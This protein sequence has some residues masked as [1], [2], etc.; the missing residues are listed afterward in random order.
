MGYSSYVMGVSDMGVCRRVLGSCG[1][2]PVRPLLLGV[3][4]GGTRFLT[5][6]VVV[7]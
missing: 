4:S 2:G 3:L 5:R 1:L 6:A 7:S